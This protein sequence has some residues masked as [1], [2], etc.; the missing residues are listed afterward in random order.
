[1]VLD[2]I[3]FEFFSTAEP[4]MLSLM[5]AVKVTDIDFEVA[6]RNENEI[7]FKIESCG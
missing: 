3:A 4:C 1:M 7:V 2:S 5:V 6:G